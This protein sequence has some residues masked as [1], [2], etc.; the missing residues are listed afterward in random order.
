[1]RKGK[2]YTIVYVSRL[3]L[4]GKGTLERVKRNDEILARV[5]FRD[6]LKEAN[7]CEFGKGKYVVSLCEQWE[8]GEGN[9]EYHKVHEKK[10]II[11]G[12]ITINHNVW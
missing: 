3:F 6:L 1:M 2:R 5:A 10:V 8:D 12:P 9:I 11:N 4:W 7:D